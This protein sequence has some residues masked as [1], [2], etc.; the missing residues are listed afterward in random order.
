MNCRDFESIARDL[1]RGGLL[2]SA[3]RERARAHAEACRPCARRLTDEQALTAGL[4]AVAASAPSEGAPVRVEGALLA[5]FRERRAAPAVAAREFGPPRAGRWPRWAVAAAAA[6][7]VLLGVSLTRLLPTATPEPKQEAHVPPAATPR[8]TPAPPR[9]EADASLSQKG[10]RPDPEPRY[11][12][13]RPRPPK[14][15]A[16][17]RN[18]PGQEL[19][20]ATSETEI[21]TDFLPLTHG[22]ALPPLESGQLMRVEMPRSA[23]TAFGL[24]MNPERADEPVKADVLMGEDGLARAIRFVR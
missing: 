3:E 1:A 24:P 23:L 18:G 8:Q 16:G 4:K 21:V 14:P 6:I 10:H 17:Q 5:A 7:L 2:D 20:A 15:A 13:R 9:D 22:E 19:N 11:I 12:A